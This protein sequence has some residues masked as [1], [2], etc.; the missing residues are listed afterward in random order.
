[1]RRRSAKRF[2]IQSPLPL[3]LSFL[4][5][6]VFFSRHAQRQQRDEGLLGNHTLEPE[7]VG[8]S[9][10]RSTGPLKH[11]QEPVIRLRRVS[12]EPEDICH[13]IRLSSRLRLISIDKQRQPIV[14]FLFIFLCLAFVALFYLCI[15]LQQPCFCGCPY[16]LFFIVTSAR[17][18]TRFAS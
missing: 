5:L 6:V 13:R 11:Q 18:S 3:H 15:C 16:Y 8:R 4:C 1:M 9:T 10:G 7:H 14:F 17:T 2:S 12:A